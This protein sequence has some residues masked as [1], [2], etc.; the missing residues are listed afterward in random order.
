MRPFVVTFRYTI[1]NGPFGSDFEKINKIEDC[2]KTIFGANKNNKI[3][4]DN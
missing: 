3:F 2:I 1:L 4:F